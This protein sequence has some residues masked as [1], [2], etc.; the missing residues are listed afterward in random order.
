ML[1]TGNNDAH[2]SSVLMLT[3][4]EKHFEDV[5]CDLESMPPEVVA[6]ISAVRRRRK[7]S[8]DTI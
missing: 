4:I 5:V 7:Y 3:S 6:K 2:L 1:I 8:N